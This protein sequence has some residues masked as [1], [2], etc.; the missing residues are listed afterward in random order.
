MILNRYVVELSIHEVGKS[1]QYPDGIKSGLVCKDLR[2]GGM[3]MMDNHHPN[4]GPHLHLDEV[5]TADDHVSDE[6]LIENFKS[7]VFRPL[8][9]KR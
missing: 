3:V 1:A 4:K 2:E 5:E 9:V 8:G 6:K 7:L